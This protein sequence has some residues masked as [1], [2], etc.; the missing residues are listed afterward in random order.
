M[1]REQSQSEKNDRNFPPRRR[2]GRIQ[3]QTHDR[4]ERKQQKQATTQ[5]ATRTQLPQGKP[6]SL[7]KLFQERRESPKHPVNVGRAS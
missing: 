1:F 5:T 4:Q 6:L 2:P 7:D 3:K